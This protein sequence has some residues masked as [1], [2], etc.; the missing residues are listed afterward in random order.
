MPI[1][2]LRLAT[3]IVNRLKPR[4]DRRYPKRGGNKGRQ[5]R[6]V[7]CAPGLPSPSGTEGDE[8]AEVLAAGAD[9]AARR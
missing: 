4:G 2:I 9:R 6:S 1:T 5:R 8:E 3:W 7:N